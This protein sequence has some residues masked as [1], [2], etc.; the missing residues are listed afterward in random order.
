MIRI[1]RDL[2]YNPSLFVFFIRKYCN[3]LIGNKT[4]AIKIHHINVPTIE[5]TF[6]RWWDGE[7]NA[8]LWISFSFENSS[9][10]LRKYLHKVITYTWDDM[11][12]WLPLDYIQYDEK[13]TDNV[14]L[15]RTTR[16][17]LAEHIN[18]NNTYWDAFYFRNMKSVDEFSKF[19]QWKQLI[20]ISNGNTL[21]KIRGKIENVIGIFEIPYRNSFDNYTHLQQ[22]IK[23]YIGSI[24]SDKNNTVIIVSWW[25]FAKALCYDLTKDSQFICHDVGAI[26][27]LYL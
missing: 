24:I 7:T 8:V 20:I 17:F 11:L 5:K 9:P 27:D 23:N 10:L 2:F 19:Y 15:W 26:F 16:I 22:E 18:K 6:I 4:K 13:N 3:V 25:P 21:E 14:A 1:I 12:I